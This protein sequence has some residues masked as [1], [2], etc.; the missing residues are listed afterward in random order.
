MFR[1]HF[2]CCILLSTMSR[3]ALGASGLLFSGQLGFSLHV[4]LTTYL[5]LIVDYE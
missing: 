1:S 4:N 2:P 5:F 3:Q